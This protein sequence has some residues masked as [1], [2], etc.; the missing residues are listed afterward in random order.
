MNLNAA[1]RQGSA[2]TS[3][4]EALR[5]DADTLNRLARDLTADLD[6]QT[7][8]QRV[9]DAGTE[10]TGA[11]FGAFFYNQVN[12]QG[13]AYL[14]YTLS[15]AP[16]EAF[17]N[18]GTPRNTALFCPTFEGTGPVRIDDVLKD[19]RYGKSAPHQG[20]PT[21]HL[22]VRS[23]LAVPVTSR[24]GEVLGGLFFGHPE[25][26]VFDE[27]A[28]RMALGIAA[29]AAVA[30]DNARL[31]AKATG[32]LDARRSV[33]SALR[34]SE[35][36][37]RDLVRLLPAAVYTCEAP[38]GRITFYN[39]HAAE[40]WGREPEIDDTDERFCGSLKLWRADGGP[41]PHS[42]TPMAI[43]LRTGREFRNQD[44]IIERP[45]G[46]RISVLL[47]ID[48]IRDADGRVIGAIN[49]FQDI[50]K[51]KRAERALQESEER[52]GRFMQHLPGLAWI[53]DAHGR[54]VYANDAA[55]KAFRTPR[56][57]LYGRTDEEV[58]ANDIARRFRENDQAALMRGTG[59]QTIETLD[60]ADGEVR[61]S[62]V[63]KFPIPGPDG[64]TAL[65]G[66]M[67]ID[68]T[69]RKRAEEAL[70]ESEQR[71]RLMADAAPVLIWVSDEQKRGIYFNEGWLRFTG[72]PI[73]KELGEG[74][75]ESIHP[76][77]LER[78]AT[79]CQRAFEHG[80]PFRMEFRMR[81]ADGE[82]RWILDHA[83]P[84]FTQEGKLAGY[85]GSCIDVTDQKH[86]ENELR[87][88]EERLRLALDAGRMGTWEWSLD[89]NRIAWSSSVEMIH[90][91]E[92]GTFGGTFEDYQKDIHPDDLELVQS[93]I[94]RAVE[95]GELDMEYRILL[96][97]GTQR[98]V[99]GRGKLLRDDS[100]K[101]VS[102]TG[103]C[104]DI[105]ER[106]NA[107]RARASLAAIV[108]STQD[109]IVSK[110]LDGR[111]TSWNAGAERLFGYTAE[112]AT[113][114]SIELIIP[115]EMRAEEHRI[116]DRLRKGER[117][118]HF[119]TV[120][121]AK[122]GKR[123][124][125]SLSISPI[126]DSNGRLV[127]A[128]KVARD[129]SERKRAEESL[130]RQFDQLQSIY[131]LSATAS[132]AVSTEDISEAALDGL[133]NGVRADRAAVLLYDDDGVMRFKSWRGLPQRYRQA[134]EGHSPWSIHDRDAQPVP[135]SDVEAEEGLA[136][137]LPTIRREG[138]RALA[139][140]PI[141]S[142]TG[143]LGK[144]MVYYNEVHEFT[145]EELQLCRALA[146]HVAFAFE[147]T[148]AEQALRASEERYRAI[149][150]GQSELVCRFRLD[151]TL[152]FVNG[153]YARLI[154]M[155]PD[156]LVGENF[157][158][159]VPAEDRPHVLTML[160]RLTPD[161]PEIR[162][163][164]RFESREG[165]RWTLWTNRALAFDE[166]GEPTEL[167]SAG[168]DI[169]DRKRAEDAVRESERRFRRMADAAPVLIWMSGRDK[170]YT[171]FNQPWL[172]FVGRPIE[173]EIGDG[174]LDN[175]HPDDLERCANTYAAKFE[176]REP[177]TLEYRLKRHD[178]EYRWI[179]DNGTPM[180]AGDHFIGYIGSCVD[181]TD[182]K[183][184]E[185]ALKAKEAELEL[186][187][188]TTPHI[189]TRCSRDLRYRFVNRSAAA[190]F[191]LEPEEMVGR[192]IAEIMG[193]ESFAVI[194]P[195][196][197]KVLRGKPVEFEAQIAY[198]YA[199]PRWMRVNFVP[200][201]D[202]HDVVIGWIASMVDI[203]ERK[204]AEEALEDN[205]RRLQA[206]LDVLPLP[207]FIADA[208]GRIYAKNPAA[209]ELWGSTEL[210]QSPDE[211]SKDYAA[212]WADTGKRV[213]S[214]EWGLARALAGGEIVASQE[215]V[216]IA[217]DGEHRTILNYAR[218]IRDA[219]GR[220][221]GA[222]AVNVDI[223]AHKR[224]EV[225][226]RE[227]EQRL[228]LALQGASAGVWMLD[229]KNDKTYWSDEFLPLYGYDQSTPRTFERWLNSVHPE[230]RER[231]RADFQ[232]R[233]KSMERDFRQ[234]FRIIHPQRGVR[235]I[236]DMGHIERDSNGAAVRCE[237]INLDMTERK[238]AEERLAENERRFREMIDALPTAIY[239]TDA[240]GR[241]THYNRAAVA[242]SGRTPELGSDHWC[243]SWKLYHPDGTPMPHDTCPMSIALREGRAV[244]GRE[245]IAERP[246]GTRRWFQP[247]PTPLRAS[248][249]TVIG[250]INMLV[251][252][253]DRKE[254]EAHIRRSEQ[255]LSDFFENASIGLHWVGPDGII[256]RVNKA[257]LDMLGYEREEYVGRHIAEFHMDQAV[258]EDILARLH[259]GE[260]LR[261]YPAELCCK[262][263]STR[264]VLINSSVLFEDGEFI[265]TRCFTHDITA[266]KQA[267]EA[268]SESE[269]QFR[270][271]IEDAPIP[272][273]LQ[274]EDGEVLQISRSWTSLTG[275]TIEDAPLFQPWLA[276][277][278]GAG[279]ED[280]RDAVHG[281]FRSDNEMHGVE[282]GVTTRDGQTRQ[283]LF[284]ASSPGTLRDGRRYIVAMAQDI[285]ARKRVEAALRESESRF[286]NMADYAPVLIWVNDR[287]G[288]EFVNRE[289]LRFV[290]RPFNDIRGMRW[291][292]YIHPDDLEHYL[293]TYKQAFAGSRAYEAEVRMRRSDG[294]Y[295]WLRTSG[296]PRL[297]VSGEIIGYVGSC[298][299][300]TNQIEARE[301]LEEHGALLEAAVRQRTA[302]LEESN[303]RLRLAERMA[304]LGTLSA[305]LGHDI[306]NI[307]IPV[308]V[309]L[310]SLAG[311][312]LTE[313][314]HE[315]VD[316]IRTSTEYLQRLSAGL[317]M[318]ASDAGQSSR[319]EAT[320]ISEWWLDAKPMMTNALPR[321]AKLET[322][323]PEGDCWVAVSRAAL[324]QIVFNLVQNAGEVSRD[325]RGSVVNVVIEAGESD[326]RVSVS[327]NGPGM[328]EEVK[329]RCLEP[330]FTTKPRGM[331]TGLG[332]SLIH[333]LVTDADGTID[334]DS[335]PGRGTT[336]TITLKR[337]RTDHSIDERNGQPRLAVVHLSDVRLQAY[338]CAELRS[339]K[340]DVALGMERLQE[341]ELIVV[342]TL[343]SGATL[344]ANAAVLVLEAAALGSVNGNRNGNPA[345]AVSEN[346][347]TSER[348]PQAIRKAIRELAQ[349]YARDRCSNE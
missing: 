175:V 322:R 226:L 42:Q 136:E 285:T 78:A 205:Q 13:E 346:V 4:D 253:T 68:I 60:H 104:A 181:I 235:W 286:R 254:A 116:L 187:A 198:S 137:F 252:I 237:G 126:R 165:V 89:T 172:N 203:T 7:L 209:E 291:S 192:S 56:K 349:R 289:Y 179:L 139:F 16:R 311:A 281:L 176:A 101:P 303:Q 183:H 162:I 160:H 23:Y 241:I 87:A 133:L 202:E 308:R 30:I 170:K 66:G 196:V 99:E 210:S 279:G 125:I 163:E 313:D 177:F 44:V 71:F 251:D 337:A 217:P 257:E 57:K 173:R 147:R 155:A 21:G 292:K 345:D 211:Y 320:Q 338:V 262:N 105:T 11:K 233:L 58:F 110:T 54:Y 35:E 246:D 134:V 138:I 184:A 145:E 228:R 312:P 301:A 17:E 88:S 117:I 242:F 229:I 334:I 112:E 297:T 148:L 127:G 36:R 295:R 240:E 157:W 113:G 85:I 327:D 244:H 206:V 268:L 18:F 159:F 61:H 227:G 271:A 293:D 265:H 248:D 75:L 331:S 152:L 309:R 276:E 86:A 63:S 5:N 282:F 341:G 250:A 216:V 150:E 12:E 114:Q 144:F 31:Y 340:Y 223:T 296:V 200:E 102:M 74:W 182:R 34:E 201:R 91:L 347:M 333:S 306:G 96:P 318:L 149:V 43:A 97:D 325:P 302:E 274:T 129:V 14:L 52:F 197:E 339:L 332:L 193:E 326:V 142:A 167:Q 236:L 103:V 132:R 225:A 213:E 256:Q 106:K 38:S 245:A 135:I 29:Q 247:Y 72:R 55:E 260:I 80:E 6:L 94:A 299:D 288:C 27:R 255:E 82:Y 70:R 266:R 100:G 305:G 143:V 189:L 37:Y 264:H 123:L 190:Q 73:E 330:F 220:I 25:V 49:V 130:Q 108:E 267:E 208:G 275:Y 1:S 323:M 287:D 243:V 28:E 15:G 9:T 124:D 212:W 329:R 238:N 239:T 164:N 26:G 79:T 120:R 141:K 115:P 310:E 232:V 324:T 290:G 273:I 118:E 76:D 146:G 98:W 270:K 261:E 284:N 3:I 154:G 8:V 188:E 156:A 294:E 269:E 84:R 224:A 166:H 194:K 222:V 20:M 45:D 65:V 258:I 219:N 230:D 343:E 342:D 307:L 111:I 300:I 92:P 344:P 67:A 53:K 51:R 263:G 214:H 304:S 195:H 348:K 277:A 33:E 158:Q 221:D 315:H 272:V 171:W 174:W 204:L 128:S 234:E 199:G 140:I 119:E 169:T 83:V 47:N 50:S 161:D 62:L 319:L 93:A 259:R 109:A 231:V 316:V 215:V 64:E 46:T 41:L 180:Q 77:D 168:M 314:L 69:D 317:R 185:A 207:L 90:G 10:V 191:G 249:G 19:P 218:P 95:S 178:G 336:F 32:E 81:R 335:E 22:P 107:E 321:S 131:R 151:G 39:E 48:P 328:T 59:M 280:M 283:W 122:D 298:T 121:L 186:V 153:A 2:Q 40:L 278:Y 24:S